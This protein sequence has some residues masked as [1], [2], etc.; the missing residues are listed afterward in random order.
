MI[1]LPVLFCSINTGAAGARACRVPCQHV[2]V[3]CQGTVRFG[4]PRETPA[5]SSNR[6]WAAASAA[7][8][9][10]HCIPS[11]IAAAWVACPHSTGQTPV[12][13]R[14]TFMHKHNLDL[15]HLNHVR[16]MH[17]RCHDGAR[18]V[19]TG[20]WYSTAWICWRCRCNRFFF[21]LMDLTKVEF[22]NIGFNHR[23]ALNAK[24]LMCT[25]TQDL[26]PFFELQLSVI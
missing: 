9:A 14:L 8:P 7:A 16:L 15:L 24:Q 1:Y 6:I 17:D 3:R 4:S 18:K 19:G 12:L 13:Q 23:N 21:F 2:A 5:P 25:L 11:L 26:S 20:T 22:R 10:R